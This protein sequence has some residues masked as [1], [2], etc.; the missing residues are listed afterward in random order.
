MRITMS[1]F[2]KYSL[3]VLLSVTLSMSVNAEHDKGVGVGHWNSSSNTDDSNL[4]G[5]IDQLL[6][7]IMTSALTEVTMSNFITTAQDFNIVA[8]VPF[9]ITVGTANGSKMKT[10]ANDEVNYTFTINNGAFNLLT[11][12]GTAS[13]SPVDD[14]WTLNITPEG[15]DGSTRAGIYTD[16]VTITLSAS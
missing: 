14:T 1:Y 3:I 7:I 5:E 11:S 13:S 16:T 15:I 6:T 2:S 10:A 12:I 9:S 4:I 8:N